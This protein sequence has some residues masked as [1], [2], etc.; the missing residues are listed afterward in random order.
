M[1]ALKRGHYSPHPKRKTFFLAET[2]KADH[3]LSE[4]FALSKYLF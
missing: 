1:F 2:T 4:T 3:Q